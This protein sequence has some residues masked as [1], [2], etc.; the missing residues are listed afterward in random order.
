[1]IAEPIHPAAG[2]PAGIADVDSELAG[3]RLVEAQWPQLPRAWRNA[4]RLIVETTHIALF[5]IG[6]LFTLMITLEVISRYVFSFSISFVNAL[7]RML[8][9]WF[10]LLGAGIALR[11]GAH[12]GFEL[13]LSRMKPGGRKVLVLFGLTLAAIFYAEMLWSG[14]YS[15]D[16][17]RM[18]TE[19]GLDISLAWIVAA[20]PV[21]CALL[22]Y[23][24]IVLMW[25]EARKP[26]RERLQP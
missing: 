2:E 18:L 22:L 10:F 4:D 26:A 5:A 1:L 11:R 13:L 21:G 23:H 9:V 16:A 7:A 17:M 24:T 20:I 25:L 6:M 14:F 12:V 8:L 15:F 19:P 3:R